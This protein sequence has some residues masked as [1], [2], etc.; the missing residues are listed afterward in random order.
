[1]TEKE[2]QKLLDSL[3]LEEKV[4][5]WFNAWRGSLFPMKWK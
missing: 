4:G 3:T 2:L 5:S 1:M